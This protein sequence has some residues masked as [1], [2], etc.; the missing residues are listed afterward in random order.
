MKWLKNTFKGIFSQK[1]MGEALSI[2]NCTS[3]KQIMFFFIE[4]DITSQIRENIY[5]SRTLGTAVALP[6]KTIKSKT[7]KNVTSH[8]MMMN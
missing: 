7:K 1:Q 3:S 5:D 8:C 4:I 2:T 6:V